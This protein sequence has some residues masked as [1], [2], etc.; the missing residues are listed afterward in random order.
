MKRLSNEQK[1]EWKALR[2]RLEQLVQDVNDALSEAQDF[3][4]TVKDEM[5]EYAAEKS[6]KW[7]ESDE[8]AAY[9]RWLG[10]WDTS[11]ADDIQAALDEFESLPEKPE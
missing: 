6:V 10:A 8:G 2:E 1:V 3:V 4:D 9:S 7:S 11:L 5:E